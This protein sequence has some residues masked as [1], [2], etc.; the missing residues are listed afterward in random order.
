MDLTKLLFMKK[1]AVFTSGA[2]DIA[3][4]LVSLFNEGDR[5]RIDVVVTDR[6]D[7]GVVGR[8]AECATDAVYITP[9]TWHQHPEEVATLLSERGI[10]LIVLDNFEQQL[11]AEVADKYAGR[12]VTA[13]SADEAPRQIVAAFAETE[14]AGAQS[15]CREEPPAPKSV[16]EEWAETLHINFDPSRMRT[17]PPPIP[18]EAQMP[19]ANP[20]PGGNPMPG[21]A[22]MQ[23]Q[24]AGA[25]RPE[26]T[27]LYGEPMPP[28]WL[29]WSVIMTV[30]CCTIPGI[31][32]IIFSSQVSSR[33]GMGDIEG[34]RRASRNAEIWIIVSFVLGV[35]SS[36]LYL[37]IMMAS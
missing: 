28:T 27:H 24:G 21:A 35:L 16:D 22:R 19:G 7:T 32:A 4:S 37:P 31:V 14:D 1:I 13:T 15:A 34:A 8:F 33:Y 12:V 30:F 29:V 10:E 25:P 36:T 20:M 17:T 2:G 5:F 11:S 6:E 18:G 26:H 23:P 9:D 3:G